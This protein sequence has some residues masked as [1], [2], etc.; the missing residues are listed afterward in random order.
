MENEYQKNSYKELCV[1]SLPGKRPDH[2]SLDEVREASNELPLNRLRR[3]PF[4][5][6]VGMLFSKPC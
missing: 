3:L 4:Q 2:F 1:G 6:L 5:S